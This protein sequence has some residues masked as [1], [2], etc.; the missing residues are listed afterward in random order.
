[1]ALAVWA[2]LTAL[3]VLGFIHG[4]WRP[5]QALLCAGFGLA[6]TWGLGGTWVR[7]PSFVTVWL[8]MGVAT[9]AALLAAVGTA[10]GDGVAYVVLRGPELTATLAFAGLLGASVASL[11]YTHQ[12]LADEVATQ[13]EHMAQ[14]RQRALER[15]LAALSAQLNPHFLFNTLNTVA[16]VV[17]ED[18]DV[19][20]D[21]VTDLAHMMRYVLR[22]T[23]RWVLLG[24]ELDV[25][26]RL[27][28]LE[29]A[30]LGERL[31]WSVEVVPPAGEV[32]IPGLL[33]QPLVENA[34]RHAVASRVEGGSIAVRAHI[35]SN[36][37]HVTVEDDGPGLPEAV[38][39]SMTT[40]GRGTEGAGGGL[41][42]TA[43]RVRL[44]WSEGQGRLVA[45]TGPSGR[46]T[47]LSLDVP[48]GGAP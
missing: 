5:G 40:P 36:R 19:A 23:A 2:G 42:A 48:V 41:Y 1:M 12:R 13:A 38:A 11:A 14:L 30:R 21:L 7:L 3:A 9:V 47:R 29:Q 18:A 45:T 15:H 31:R 20:E 37:L 46:G 26:R 4:T 22:S 34:V 35:E 17:H 39:T 44:A 33:V 43:E 28:R 25:V 32:E 10:I 24:D 6:A 8:A 27:L 16:Q